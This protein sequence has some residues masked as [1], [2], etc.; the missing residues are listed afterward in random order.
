MPKSRLS[1]RLLGTAAV[2]AL[3]G[4]SSA[5]QAVETK[6]GDFEITLDTTVSMGASMRVADRNEQFLPEGNGGPVDP[7]ES[8]VIFQNTVAASSLA[9]PGVVGNFTLTN[10][11]D[12]YDGSVNADDARLNFDKGDL[13]GA[14]IKANHDLLV[15]YD[16]YT[17]F[18]RAVG[19]YDAVLND[20]N[21]GD[22]SILTEQARGDVGRNY[23]LLDAF[24]SANYTVA[25]M[26]VNLRVGKQVIN[27]GESTFILGGNNVFNPIDVGA[28]RRP[29]S[30][31]KE[32]LLPVNAVS[33][34]ITLPESWANISLSGY[35][36]L[37][38]EPFELDPAGSPF[39]GSDSATLGSGFGGNR[40]A[41]SFLTGSPYSGYRLNCNVGFNGNTGLATVIGLGFIANPFTASGSRVDCG[42]SPF[43]NFTTPYTIGNHE[44]VKLGLADSLSGQ[45]L[46]EQ[47]QGVVDHTPD[48][49]ARD[50][51]QFGISA[52][53]LSDWFG[54][55]EFGAY[56][57]RYHS[58]LPFVGERSGQMEVGMST[59]SLST[60]VSGVAG[61]FA[62]PTGCVGVTANPAS[63]LDP[64]LGVGA[65]TLSQVTISDPQNLLNT[66][67]MGNI[68]AV[69]GGSGFAGAFRDTGGGTLAVP[70]TGNFDTVR[71]LALVNCALSLFQSGLINVPGVGVRPEMFNGSEL[72]AAAT[73]TEFFLEY[74]ED[75]DVYGASFS[76]TLWGWGVQGDFTYRP[77][78]PFQIDTDSMTIASGASQCAFPA[79]VSDLALASIGGFEG[80]NTYKGTNCDP[81]NV[82]DRY[83]AG[84][85]YNE[86]YTAQIGTTATFSQ[87]DWWVDA[88]G[89]DLGILVTEVG[90]VH[91]PAVE[92]TWIDKTGTGVNGAN[93]KQQY[94]NIGCQG[95]DLPLG[96][97]LGLDHKAS[98]HCRP[99][100][101]SAGLVLLY[102]MQYNN[103]FGSG[104]V[105]SPT[106]TYSYDFYGTTPAPYGNYAEDRQAASLGVT[107]TLN[108]NFRVG[109]TYTNFFGGGIKNKA[110][111]Q[112]FASLTASY[113]F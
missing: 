57:Q 104:F 12:N 94:Q 31:I 19:F 101:N 93:L 103:A 7:R 48:H 51:G 47:Q 37:D 49:L 77:D 6:F 60:Q 42:D 74:P 33:G 21:A 52:R 3:V 99:T 54:G 71:N 105:I 29:G 18:V 2:V 76:T 65:G 24:V 109:A 9:N 26:P 15:K 16:N 67:S 98:E 80:L 44:N 23:E 100:D 8:G 113:S 73:Q 55:A 86:M 92:D 50:D 43:I 5:A 40:N 1:V 75:I 39:S 14:N 61:R 110:T 111:D 107:G 38:W 68:E 85:I 4:A 83:I 45:G 13:I 58:R 10:N 108:N 25:D 88:L 84:E 64:R 56:Y 97:L 70:V 102:S 53:Y 34:S 87:S 17:L 59:T 11:V 20:P 72:L 66:T 32:A 46:T 28:F 35:Y 69:L 41:L 112:D 30:E 36:A 63:F 27:W 90:F 62:T 89:A 96:G 78:A 106:I 82:G 95:S 81:T 22:R 79:S 91:V